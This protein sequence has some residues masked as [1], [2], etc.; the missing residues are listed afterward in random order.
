MAGT[1]AT[2]AQIQQALDKGDA[3]DWFRQRVFYRSSTAFYRSLELFLG[4]LT[5][6][7]ECF[8][9]WARVTGYYSRFYFLQAFL[10]LLQ[11]TYVYINGRYAV[12]LSDG[13]RIHY[14]DQQSLPKTMQVRG[15][16]EQWWRLMEA[17]KHPRD[18]PVDN[19]EMVIGR[20]GFNPKERNEINYSF[21]YLEG[22]PELEWFDSGARQMLSHFSP[23]RRRDSDVTDIER[24][25]EECDPEGVDA[26]DFYTDDGATLW[27]YLATY[28][29]LL[30]EL[31][32]EQRFIRTETMAALA[33]VHLAIRSPQ[34]MTGIVTTASG[35]LSDG[36]DLEAWITGWRQNPR[37]GSSFGHCS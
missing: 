35:I 9:T 26:G 30:K 36:F 17:V 20:L 8:R 24:F 10:N 19:I 29:K 6:E 37:R 5:L 1:T 4:F 3:H 16:H 27:S 12:M 34:L 32:F 14:R 2:P 28:L 11:A 31:G 23:R 13:R 18:Y 25:F 7:R 33:E 15:S 21:E 22:F